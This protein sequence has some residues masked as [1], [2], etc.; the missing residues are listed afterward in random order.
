MLDRGLI[1]VVLAY[2]KMLE[3]FS[4]L[5]FRWQLDNNCIWRALIGHV[6]DKYEGSSLLKP[7]EAF[8]IGTFKVWLRRLLFDVQRIA[9]GMALHVES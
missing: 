3:L 8:P 7:T 2:L 6:M 5:P 9:N 4:S 1:A